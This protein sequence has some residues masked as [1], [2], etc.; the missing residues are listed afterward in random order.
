MG[1]RHWP[2]KAKI[3]LAGLLWVCCSVVTSS[4]ELEEHV[5]F[6]IGSGS[7]GG[8]YFPVANLIASAL[9]GTS[10]KDNAP[11]GIP[12]L[13]AVAQV[14]NGSV[15][16]VR[17]LAE[18]VLEAGLVQADVAYA[19]YSG[20]GIFADEGPNPDLRTI[21]N[22]YPESIHLVVSASKGIYT[23]EDLAGKRVSLGELGSGSMLGATHVLNSYGLQDDQLQRFYLK[24]KL[25]ATAL[26][27]QR[28]D[29]F[30]VIVGHPAAAIV[31]LAVEHPIGLISIEG[32]KAQALQEKEPY[33]FPAIIPANTYLGV[34]KTLT[35]TVGAQLLVSAQLDE[36]LIYQVT[37]T[38]WETRTYK[39]LTEGHPTGRE[40][41][42]KRA[43]EGVAIPLHPGAERFYR[44]AG[45]LSATLTPP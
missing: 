36:E 29:A 34:T 26:R 31:D 42:L 43:L 45:L 41:V 10:C 25:A 1:A 14:A 37:R 20:I 21:A 19:A 39:I 18:G 4:I 30:F 9:D 32:L 33:F 11:C 15:A 5:L 28:L 2:I 13:L 38:L 16:N 8:T 40:I 27:E 6:R 24:P 12:G 35:L 23:V 17:D 44:E 22:L 3:A 7:L